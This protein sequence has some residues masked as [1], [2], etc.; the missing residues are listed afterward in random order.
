MMLAV[1]IVPCSFAT[2]SNPNPNVTMSVVGEQNLTLTRNSEVS[3][4]F[5]VKLT[6]A[7]GLPIEGAEVQFFAYDPNCPNA[8]PPCQPSPHLL[9]GNF[10]EYGESGQL[11]F[12][13]T[14]AFGVARSGNFTGGS[15]PGVYGTF[16]NVR[17]PSPNP[18]NCSVLNGMPSPRAEFSIRQEFAP[19][20]P[21]AYMN[22][23]LSGSWYDPMQSGQGLRLE[24]GDDFTIQ[25]IWFTFS[26]NGAREWIYAQGIFAANRTYI[27][28]D[29]HVGA[30]VGARFPPAFRS[31]GVQFSPWG[32]MT[33]R[34]TGCN[35]ATL[36]WKST[37][38]DYGSGNMSLKR[39]TSIKGLSCPA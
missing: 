34:F 11:I 23:H 29:A 36:D 20:A 28:L 19:A 3:K 10:G 35:D 33:I 17:C 21:A 25:A 38:P 26:P 7:Q 1:A 31:S 27:T 6:N 14:D 32:K 8:I 13:K 37:N 15:I 5:A 4:G 18:M 9:F 12:A 24:F 2:V 22:G 30:G 39:L 16:A